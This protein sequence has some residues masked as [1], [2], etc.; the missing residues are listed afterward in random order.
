MLQ[1]PPTAVGTAYSKNYRQYYVWYSNG[2]L[3]T[4]FS[5]GQNIP[6]PIY[7]IPWQAWNAEDFTEYKPSI[8]N[9]LAPN[10]HL[11]YRAVASIPGSLK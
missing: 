3:M 6:D 8:H 11:D 5:S 7:A 10:V 9:Y 2:S 4:A 1:M